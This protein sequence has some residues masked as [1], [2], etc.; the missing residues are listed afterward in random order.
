MPED[1]TPL[2]TSLPCSEWLGWA[3]AVG[4]AA[5]WP[6]FRAYWDRRS[7]SPAPLALTEI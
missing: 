7:V 2:W 6:L 3:T 4:G 1:R 5:L